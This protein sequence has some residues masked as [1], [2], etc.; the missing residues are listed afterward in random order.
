MSVACNFRAI[1]SRS[2]D[3]A[4]GLRAHTSVNAPRDIRT[5]SLSRK[6]IAVDGYR[7]PASR[8]ASPMVS[9]RPRSSFGRARYPP[10]DP[11]PPR[12]SSRSRRSSRTRPEMSTNMLVA[13]SPCTYAASPALSHTRFRPRDMNRRRRCDSEHDAANNV[14][15]YASGARSRRRS[16]S[17]APT[18]YTTHVRGSP[19]GSRSGATRSVSRR[20]DRVRNADAPM[21][22]GER[23]GGPLAPLPS[24]QGTASDRV[25]PERIKSM[26]SARSPS[27]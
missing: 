9:P 22:V 14:A 7:P 17:A 6:H 21:S 11:S 19:S 13:S 5:S 1:A 20:A 15:T 24:G 26:S 10:F 12:S 8:G 25:V 4:V 2:R 16:S 27:A 23:T 18:E 3:A